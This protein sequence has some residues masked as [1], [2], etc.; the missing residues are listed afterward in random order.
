MVTRH[1]VWTSYIR[2]RS[3]HVKHTVLIE[4]IEDTQAI[5]TNLPS[6]K[7]PTFPTRLS[8]VKKLPYRILVETHLCKAMHT[9]LVQTFTT[10]IYEFCHVLPFRVLWFPFPARKVRKN[11]FPDF[12]FV[13]TGRW[14]VAP[15]LRCCLVLSAPR[16]IVYTFYCT[17]HWL[18]LPS[19]RLRTQTSVHLRVCSWC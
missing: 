10:E 5:D 11:M 8:M 14:G 9:K 2:V 7:Y 3:E 6:Q 18:P 15:I 16:Q 4:W 19:Y 17:D 12:S 13:V 1:F